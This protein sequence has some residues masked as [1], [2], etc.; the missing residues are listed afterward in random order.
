[1]AAIC[2]QPTAISIRLWRS[3]W[4]TENGVAIARLSIGHK[5]PFWNVT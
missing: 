1:M 4:R 5:Q 2:L 3:I